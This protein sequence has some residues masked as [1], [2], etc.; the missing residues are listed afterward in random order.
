M[1]TYLREGAGRPRAAGKH[2]LLALS[3]GFLLHAWPV[4]AAFLSAELRVNGL[5]CPFCA[6]GIEKKLLDVDGV[7][8]VE[9]FLDEGRITLSFRTDSEATV[10]DLEKAVRKAGFELAGLRLAVGGELLQEAGVRFIAHAA[11]TFRLLEAHAGTP[12]PVS[13]ET[14]RRL[15][16]DQVLG[17]HPLVIEG[18]VEARS[19]VEPTLILDGS[20][21][22]ER[23]EK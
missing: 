1:S 6:F 15:R 23:R 20:G 5:T 19:A 11:M 17:Q 22:A 18:A 10:D 7:R 21:S 9:V 3:L 8:D 4:N 13:A 2:L 14:L 12:G 16:D